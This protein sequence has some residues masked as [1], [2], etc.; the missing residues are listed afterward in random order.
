MQGIEEKKQA[1]KE[2]LK[3]LRKTRKQSI[4]AASL[5]MKERKKA[6]DAIR[7][8]LKGGAKTVPELAE[9]AGMSTSEAMWTVAALKKYGEI[10]EGQ[11]D[12]GYFRYELV[13][14]TEEVDHDESP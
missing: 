12:G 2:A 7:Q 6:I 1:R 5:R 3:G 11:K 9:G 10:A 8:Q 4:E 13:G 14:T